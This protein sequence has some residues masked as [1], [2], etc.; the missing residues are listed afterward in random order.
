LYMVTRPLLPIDADLIVQWYG[1]VTRLISSVKKEA[2]EFAVAL[3][4]RRW[5]KLGNLLRRHPWAISYRVE[6]FR[7]I[8]ITSIVK[9]WTRLTSVR[10]SVGYA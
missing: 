9:R 7:P 2:R 8:W 6:H 5:G 10:R 3:L 1:L 4:R